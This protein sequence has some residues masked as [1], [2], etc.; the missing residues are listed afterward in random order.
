MGGGGVP[1]LRTKFAKQYLTASIGPTKVFQKLR[2]KRSYSLKSF[3][4]IAEHRCL[5]RG[6]PP[7]AIFHI[8]DNKEIQYSA[9]LHVLL[10][11]HLIFSDFEHFCQYVFIVFDI[12][13]SWG[14]LPFL[15]FL[16]DTFFLIPNYFDSEYDILLIPNFFDKES[17]TNFFLYKIR[18]FPKNWK[19]LETDTNID[20]KF[21]KNLF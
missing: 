14:H 9:M 4:K 20:T 21:Y 10:Q 3:S 7:Y 19:S 12:L 16:C 2:S 1:Q 8:P 18:Y 15:S 11:V 13:A 17:N 5:Y 6:S